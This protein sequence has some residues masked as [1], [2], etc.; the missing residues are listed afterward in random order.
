[1]L[2]AERTARGW[3]VEQVAKRL[4]CSPSKVS[5]METGQRGAS[6]RDIEDLCEIYALEAAQRRLLIDLAAEGKQQ[7]SWQSRKLPYSTY[8][9]LESDAASIYDFGLG[10]VPGLLQTPDYA[11]AVL[12]TIRPRLTEDIVEQ[13][14]AGRLDRQRRLLSGQR[15]ELEAIIDESVLHRVAGN[16][17]VMR[18]QLT[19]LLE[20]SDLPKVTVRV[21]PYEAGLLPVT[22]NKFII[23]NFDQP[24]VP[25]LVFVEG[26][27]GDLYIDR[28][29]DVKAYED[30]F[31]ALRAIAATTSQTRGIIASVAAVFDD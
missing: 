24:T 11:T 15:Q 27:T 28:A 13:R 17:T 29:E 16:R 23:L 7:A 8:V 4:R 22:N 1:M 10:L 6:R 14:L 31:T 2:R 20:V 19:H 30:A 9:G 26:L 18:S 21:V 25:G 5:R 3:T 12:Q